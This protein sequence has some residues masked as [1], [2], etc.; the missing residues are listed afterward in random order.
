MNKIM[1]QKIE[2]AKYLG[3]KVFSNKWYSIHVM[4]F[5]HGMA[6]VRIRYKKRKNERGLWRWGCNCLYFDEC[7]RES[8]YDTW[9]CLYFLQMDKTARRWFRKV[10]RPC[11]EKYLLP[12]GVISSEI[13]EDVENIERQQCCLYEQPRMEDEEER[14]LWWTN[15][16]RLKI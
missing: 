7:R 11:F 8:V 2:Y 16:G 15:K 3:V 6:N 10:L 1:E 13:A 4:L 5:D 12:N 14:V 9:D